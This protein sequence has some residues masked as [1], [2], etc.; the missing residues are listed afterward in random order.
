MLKGSLD[1]TYS[2][3]VFERDAAQLEKNSRDFLSRAS[4]LNT[5][6]SYIVRSIQPLL[7]DLISILT[8]L[9]YPEFCWSIA[10]YRA[11]MR[12]PTKDFTPGFGGLFTMQFEN[13]EV[14]SVF[15]TG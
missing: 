5:T 12:Q 11:Q 14:A 3:C 15:P 2:S 13:V 4:R 6:A 10:Y 9:F 1:T 7:T 8:D